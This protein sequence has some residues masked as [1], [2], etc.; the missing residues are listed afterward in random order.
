MK[1]EKLKEK[2]KE[3]EEGKKERGKE[4][5]KDHWDMVIVCVKVSTLEKFK[6]NF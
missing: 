3:E 4:K 5:K 1:S 6:F 2:E